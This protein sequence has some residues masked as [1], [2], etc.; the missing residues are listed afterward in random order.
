MIELESVSYSY[1][2]RRGAAVPALSAISCRLEAGE[3]VA[4]TGPSGSGK[5]TL[6]HLMAGLLRP[7]SGV[8]R[9]GGQD[10]SD[11]DDD[12]LTLL[13]RRDIGFVFQFFNLLPHLTAEENAAFALLV[14][15]APVREATAKAREVLSSLGLGPR[16]EH[17]PAE[18][19]GGELQRVAIARALLMRPKVLFADEP[20]G[21][22]DSAA[23]AIFWQQLEEVQR[24]TA[25]TLV[26]VT[27][28]EEIAQRAGRR[29][30]LFDGRLVADERTS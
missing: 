1:T 11:L 7:S 25:A 12:L 5:S 29:L 4:L 27:H 21:C 16:A 15:G 30:Q 22:L 28:N 26:V 2:R 6:L 24:A 9:F 23:S 18:L 10:L 19:S 3:V 20:T 13:R 17:F 14:G 8:V